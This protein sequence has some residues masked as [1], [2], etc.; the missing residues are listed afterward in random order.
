MF[1]EG[2]MARNIHTTRKKI[3]TTVTF[4]PIGIAKKGT[5]YRKWRY[6][7]WGGSRDVGKTKATKHMKFCMVRMRKKKRVIWCSFGV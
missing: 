7:V 1:V 2:D 5:G 6:F 3:K 4:V